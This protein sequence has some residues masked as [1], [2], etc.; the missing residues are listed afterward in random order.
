MSKIRIKKVLKSRDKTLEPIFVILLIT[1]II[2]I[3][4]FIFNLLGISGYTTELRT[5]E[6]TL[7][8]VNNIF[9][10]EG[11]KYLLT[12]YLNNFLSLKPLALI[13]IALI[14]TSILEYSGFL[15]H[16]FTP[17]KKIKPIY[18]TL[19]MVFIGIISTI[20]GDYSYILLL[21]IAGILYKYIGRDSILGILTM[22]ISI[23]AGYGAGMFYNY[24]DYVLGRTT[25]ASA[26]VVTSSYN[27]S[28][29]SSLFIL[30]SSALILTVVITITIEKYL[31]KKY[32]RCDEVDNIKTSTKALKISSIVL[33]MLLVLFIYCIIPGLP[34][35]GRLLSTVETEYFAKIFGPSAPLKDGFILV[36]LA[37]L[38]V[39]GLIYGK[40]SRNIKSFKDCS[41]SLVSQFKNSG[42]IFAIM[43]F[44]SIMFAVLNWTNIP[45]VISANIIDLVGSLQF[46]GLFLIL[47]VF[48]AIV[49][50]S[51]LI[52]YSADK[53]TYIAP[54]FIPLLM[55]ANIS[56]SFSQFIYNAAD[57]V[58]KCFSPIYIY[59]LITIG[60]VYKYNKEDN[61]GLFKTMKKIM[62]IL[63]I[64]VATWAII[65]VGWYLIGFPIG[66][67]SSITL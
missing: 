7:V 21:P 57:S 11:I 13:V 54:V 1:F 66:I 16:I 29:N 4:S 42:Y 22:F 33:L 18:V 60:F 30:I 48:I 52:P 53:W 43:F 49:I 65:L 50:I 32:K 40:I 67:N 41:E 20:I 3:L 56:P 10:K 62:P 35:S 37:I 28:M 5:L 59:F 6:T 26:Q 9:S 2:G 47:T 55:R 34:K 24:Q 23:T 44:F 61:I 38:S 63:A 8:T 45:L 64:A 58:G 39:V 17:L 51:I 12:N 31:S 19:F 15:K 27:Y 36:I 46:S 14:S 25:E